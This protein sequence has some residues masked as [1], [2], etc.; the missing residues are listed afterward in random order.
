MST[1]ATPETG[2]LAP[3]RVKSISTA[4]NNARGFASRHPISRWYLYPLATRLVDALAP[5][6]VRPTHLTLCGLVAA[7]GAMAWLVCFPARA[8]WAAAPILLAWF[9]D[10]TDGLLARRQATV[11]L[12]GAWLDTNLDELIDLGLQIAVAAAAATRTGTTW[13][14]GLLI[15][16]L[17]GKYLFLHGLREENTQGASS[18]ESK[19]EEFPRRGLVARLYHLPG[20]ADIRLHALF[21]MVLFGWLTVELAAVALYYNLRWIARYG[22]VIRRLEGSR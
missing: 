9:F 17:A 3:P 1:T 21:V 11:S 20:N 15:A 13:P 10:R 4:R 6:R 19:R 12:R 18:P 5:T 2:S 7:L 8:P 14:W 16:F 22:L